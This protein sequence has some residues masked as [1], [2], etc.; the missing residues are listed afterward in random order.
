[1]AC[2]TE[3]IES[4]CNILAPLGEVRSRKMMGDNLIYLNEK[5]VATACDNLLYIKKLPVLEDKMSGCETGKPYDGAKDHYILDLN[6]PSFV[7][8]VISNLWDELPFP[9]PK[10]K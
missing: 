8:T 3:F 2:S 6:N 9:K 5:C 1:M 10:K 7:R 4:V